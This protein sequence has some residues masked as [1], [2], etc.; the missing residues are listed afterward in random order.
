MA[1]K[2]KVG[3]VLAGGSTEGSGGTGRRFARIFRFFQQQNGNNNVFLL[4][5]DSM[6]ALMRQSFIDIGNKNV[7]LF[8]QEPCFKD[9]SSIDKYLHYLK[10]SRIL[11]NLTYQNQ[12]DILHFTLPYSMFIPF[13]FSKNRTTLIFSMTAA[14]GSLANQSWKT[15]FAYRIYLQ[16]A[17]IIDTLYND[18]AKTYPRYRRKTRVS[19][20]S[21]TDYTH[22]YPSRRKQRLI[23]F[24][25]RLEPFKSPL[26]FLETALSLSKY[27]RQKRWQF[28]MLGKGELEK[29]LRTLIHIHRIGDIVCLNAIPDTST[30][31]NKSSIFVSLQQQENY[32]SQSLLEAMAAGN[33]IIATDVGET[34]RLANQG[35][36]LLIRDQSANALS[37][38]ILALTEN[39]DLMQ[40]LGEN[41]RMSI[42]NTHRID[43]FAEYLQKLW[44]EVR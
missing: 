38:A 34:G 35:N 26:L 8:K 3:I 44:L 2:P 28:I 18:F 41:A 43:L 30:V 21:F 24:A 37:Q 1:E 11:R 29:E 5:Y 20:C 14:V 42:I 7:L 19:P 23:V 16:K 10:L 40:R 36:A 25:G 39:P 31:L 33:A 32:P 22:F 9:L 27:L 17:D 6:L 12:I 4:T 13:L 15:K